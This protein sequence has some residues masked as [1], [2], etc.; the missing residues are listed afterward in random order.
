MCYT[1]S[2]FAGQPL[3]AFCC[4]TLNFSGKRRSKVAELAG[5]SLSLSLVLCV[6]AE[7]PAELRPNLW[8][9]RDDPGVQTA[10]QE[11]EATGQEEQGAGVW[12]VTTGL[13]LPL[14]LLSS[15]VTFHHAFLPSFSF[16]IFLPLTAELYSSDVGC[17]FSL[18]LGGGDVHVFRFLTS[19]LCF[20]LPSAEWAAA[21]APGDCPEGL[22]CLQQRKVSLFVHLRIYLVALAA[23]TTRWSTVSILV[24]STRS[25]WAEVNSPSSILSTSEKNKELED[26]QNNNIEPAS[27]LSG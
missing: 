11:E 12:W 22:Y 3:T 16:S 24:L 20:F 1:V 26:G 8:A 14:L 2:V 17:W 10:A 15:S 23:V 21:A 13:P 7:A 5:H 19:W 9:G 27:F 18:K 4:H 25:R 6:P